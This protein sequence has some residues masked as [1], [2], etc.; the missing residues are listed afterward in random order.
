MSDFKTRLQDEKQH[1]DERLGK[2]KTFLGTTAYTELPER[3]QDLLMEQSIVMTSY[4]DILEER[5][6]LLD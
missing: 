5:L 2:L 4:S 6:S 1:L 3:Q